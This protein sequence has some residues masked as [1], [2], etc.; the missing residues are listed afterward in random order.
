MTSTRLISGAAGL[1]AGIARLAALTAVKGEGQRLAVGMGT[2]RYRLI[3]NE[4]GP[5]RVDIYDDIGGG[6]WF[7]GG[8]SAQ[9]V[10]AQLAEIDGDV[11]VHINSG[12][13]DVFDGIAIYNAIAQ[14]AGNVT[15]I[16]DGIAASIAS[17]IAQGGKTRIIAPGAMM[18][19]HDALSMC[20]G[21][22]A[23]MREVADLL[24]QVSDNIASVYA[25]RSGTPAG[26]RDAM[27]AETWY[28]AD[29]AVN[30]GLADKLAERP[31]DP[32]DVA[33]HDFS[34]FA[35]VPG[36]LKAAAPPHGP[37]TGTHTHPH[38]AYGSQ[39]G[40]ATHEHEHTHDGDASHRHSHDGDSGDGGASD[41]AGRRPAGAAEKSCQDTMDDARIREIAAAVVAEQLHVQ[42]AA[43]DESAWDGPAAMSWASGQDNPEAAFQAICAGEKT[44]GEP[45]TQAH[46]ALPHHK[47]SGD[48]PNR[49]GVSSALGR[50]PQTQ[51]LKS[52]S[53]ARSHLEA[54]QKAMGSASSDDAHL[55]LSGVDPEEIRAALRG[56]T[57]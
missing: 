27:Q 53:A 52:E 45:D 18:M 5:A 22:A 19:I 40:D 49:S 46:W 42:N 33:A 17:V 21:F 11:E 26:W 7:S 39:G 50:L 36:W 4:T 56:A 16:V 34:L 35:K 14:R 28:N 31:A 2:A 13:G 41:Q 8:V 48:P 29:Q 47:H 44:T 24:D 20:I 25:S 3:R 55:D 37:M 57:E 51:D 15:T 12:G 38:P 10:A 54:H 23:D 30:A 43:A 1:S 9:D 6:G 32:G